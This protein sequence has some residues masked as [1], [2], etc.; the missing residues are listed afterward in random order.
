MWRAAFTECCFAPLDA[1]GLQGI[2]QVEQL[3]LPADELGARLSAAAIVLGQ[4]AYGGEVLRR[5]SE[6]AWLALA[7]IGKDG[8][9]V[10][11]AAAAAAA[12]LATLAAEG[13]ERARQQRFASE[14]GFEQAGEKLLSL[15]QLGAERTEPIVH[16]GHP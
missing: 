7:T 3:P 5:R 2:D 16:G 14:A 12:R 9:L 15:A 6:V 1:R 11:L 13:V 8:A 4:S 10:Q